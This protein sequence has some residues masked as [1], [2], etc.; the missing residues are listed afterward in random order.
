MRKILLVTSVSSMIDQFNLPN[1]QLLQELGYEVHV[2]SNFNN[3]GTIPQNHSLKLKNKLENNKVKCFQVDFDRNPFNLSK[4]VRA[5][6]QIRK[7]LKNGN[8][9]AVHSHSPIGGAIS[10]I[11]SNR[12]RKDGLKSIYTAHGFHFFKGGS[13]K[14]WFLFYPV[15]KFLSRKTD[16][17]ITINE[18]DYKLSN[19][20]F[21]AK[22]DVK[23]PGIGVDTNKFYRLDNVKLLKEKYNINK[24][25][26]VLCSVGELNDNKNHITILKAL[27]IL[28]TE[29]NIKNIKYIICG[30][31]ENESNL[32]SYINENHLEDHVILLGYIRNINEILNVSEV[33]VFPSKREG[34]GMAALEAMSV[35]LPLLTSNVHG[36]NDYSV[37]KETGFKCNPLDYNCFAKKIETLYKNE[38]LVKQFAINNI[39]SV[40]KYRLSENLR[41]MKEIYEEV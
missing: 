15:E 22:K 1:I 26:F 30:Q 21:Y 39:D 25:E 41:I 13:K 29:K 7:I 2:A 18:E 14:N 19:K 36:I 4:T 17:L 35:G 24:N 5:S 8:Y 20:K 23:I 12:Y 31:G 3:S 9:N 16:V 10:R 37:D 11:F 6:N 40:K 32:K 38:W 28:K 27:N 34:L 33:F